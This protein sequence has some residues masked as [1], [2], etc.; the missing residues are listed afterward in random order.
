MNEIINK[1]ADEF[2]I[3][4]YFKCKCENCTDSYKDFFDEELNFIIYY[5]S[6][7]I[8]FESEYFIF[9]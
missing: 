3:I 7:I 1:R 4:L 2:G 8:D 9:Q 6:K 5:E